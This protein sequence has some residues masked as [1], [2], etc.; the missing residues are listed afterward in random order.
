MR[1][2]ARLVVEADERSRS[3][4]RELRSHAPLTLLPRRRREEPSGA[5]V[6]HLVG[7]A[8]SPLGGDDLDLDVHVGA[9]ARLLLRGTAAT[10]A[11]P[12]HRPGGSRGSVRIEVADGGTVEY[13]PEPT[14]VT[15]R[16]EHEAELSVRMGEHARLCCREVLVLGRSGERP[17]RL[18]SRLELERAGTALLRNG[19][20]TA[21]SRLRDS[22]AYLGGARV[23]ATEAV[24]WDRD[25]VE[26]SGDGWALMP[27]AGGGALSTVLAGDVVTAGDAL[28]RARAAHPCGE[29]LSPVAG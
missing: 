2:R 15:S 19:F 28:S 21:D 3:V 20:D 27:L 16:A 22:H 24:V 18:R 1:S 7:S 25:P 14:V 8:T 9:G 23:L 5:V 11:L 17:G 13:L 29:E 4:V 6:V 12:G 26:C 10:L